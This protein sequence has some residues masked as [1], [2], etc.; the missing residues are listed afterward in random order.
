VKVKM[1]LKQHHITDKQDKIPVVQKVGYGLGAMSTNVAVNSFGNLT[2]LI[3]NAGLGISPVLLG[4]AQFVP[5]LW[6]AIT[7][8][9]VGNM[10][11][12]TRSRFGRR[13]PYIFVGAFAL[14]LA[15]ALLWMAPKGWNEYILF[16]YILI[17][18]LFFFTATTIYDVPRGALGFEMTDDYHER[19]RLFAYCSFLIN[20]GALTTPWLYFVATRKIFKDEVEGM[21]YVGLIMGVLML[22][23]GL[24][25]A[26]VCKERH[27]E[28]VKHQER[29][30]FW[31]GFA[32]TCKNRTFVWLLAIVLPVTIGF[33][34]VNGFSQYIMLY[35]VYGGDKSTAS[36]LMG[37]VGTLWATLSLPG[38]FLMA[39][40]ATRLGKSKTV[41]IFLIIMAVGN[42]LKVVC[43][44]KTHPWLILIPTASLSLGMLVLFSL[45]YA[46]LADICDEDEL[47]TGKRREGSYQAVYGWWWKIG[48]SGAFLVSGFLLKFTG[49][50]AKLATQ[51]DSTLFWL[52][53]WEIGLPSIMCLISVLLLIKYP[54][55]EQRAYEIKDLLAKR[56]LAAFGEEKRI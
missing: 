52:R 35:Y 41:M 16:G 42:S 17:A 18:S 44:S 34:F 30:K 5:R 43:Y 36:I 23:G 6:D 7:D 45:V 22:L 51:S 14:G 38:V 9:I 46:M 4:V 10:S 55:T 11:D 12:N 28:Q 2:L 13:R 39:Y 37:W 25:C 21:K 8:P 50:D 27:V 48:I 3:Y 31:D 24:V 15:F 49:F 1:D 47:N 54:L 19:T 56:K 20:V 32:M 29:V 33:Y 40:I 53:V 26:L